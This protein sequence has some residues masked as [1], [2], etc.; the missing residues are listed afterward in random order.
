MR[1]LFIG[2]IFGSTGRRVLAENLTGILNENKIDVCIANG[3]NVAGGRG[4]TKNIV[5]KL[6]KYGIQII[7]GGNH[8]MYDEEIYDSSPPVDHLL[9]P[10]N[11]QNETKGWGKTVYQLPDGRKIGVANLL[12]RTFMDENL[13]CPFQTGMAAAKELSRHTPIIIIDFHAEATSEKICFANYLDGNVSAV[14]GTHTHV[15]TADER[16]LPKGTA[17]ISDVGMTGPEKSAIG[18][19]LE[20]VLQK[21]L[22]QSHIRFEPA[23]E[24][25]MFN[26]VVLDIDDKS[27]KANSISRIYKRVTFVK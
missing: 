21:Y 2:D 1:I 7:S 22:Y 11:L 18:M 20:S 10:L 17:F 14:L 25:P 5:K 3:E 19:K 26:A 12:G 15:Q 9:R 23:T 4:I 24:G 6:H 27:G 16:I 8:S 13:P